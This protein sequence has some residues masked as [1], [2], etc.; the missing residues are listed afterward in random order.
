MVAS[1]LG[2]S[3]LLIHP[4]DYTARQ[5]N[6]Q[7][8]LAVAHQMQLL[9]K[10]ADKEGSLPAVLG[11]QEKPV[12]DT[13]VP[14]A[15]SGF[16]AYSRQAAMRL[17]VVTDFSYA[18]ETLIQAGNKRFAITSIQIETN[19]KTRES[20]LFKSSWEHVK[21]SGVA[22]MRAFLMYRPYAV[23]GTLGTI[24]LVLGLVPFARFLY[25]VAQGNADGHLV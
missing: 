19:P 9:K 16:R 7:R 6:A 4:Q 5:Y 1:L 3:L 25:F 15:P 20:R 8:W 17:N 12:G 10:Y 18:M 14:D 11:E 22:I 2:L 24:L 23:F 13:N 21:K